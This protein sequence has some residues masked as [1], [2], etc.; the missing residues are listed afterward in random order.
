MNVRKAGELSM[1]LQRP[2]LMRK[3][4]AAGYSTQR[5]FARELNNQRYPLRV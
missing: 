2:S 4:I 1:V 5:D 3:R